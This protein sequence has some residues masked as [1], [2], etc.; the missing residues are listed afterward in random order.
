MVRAGEA[1]GVAGRRFRAPGGVRTYPRRSA[2]LHHF[3]DGLSRRCSRLWALASIAFLLTFVVP[4]F[5][6]V[7]QD[8]RMKMPLPTKIMLEASRILQAYG[9]M[10]AAARSGLSRWFRYHSDAAGRLWWDGFRLR[11][12]GARAM[13]CERPKRR[14]SRAPWRR[15]W[16]TACRWCNHRHRGR[17]SEQQTHCG[18]RSNDRVTGCEAR[19]RHRRS[20]ATDRGI[21]AAGVASTE[22][23]RRDGPA[24][25]DVLANGGNLRDRHA[26]CHPALHVVFEPLV[27]LVMGIIVGALILSMLL[28]I[29][30]INEVAI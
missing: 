20:L 21:S 29:T 26:L 6:S 5:A 10:V 22:R 9:W 16:R 14:G 18:I 1:S 15:W 11:I 30:S 23:R 17:H 13:R 2:Q 28:A 27:I 7:F 24:G 4:R 8:S 25:S 3:G 19:R 12:A